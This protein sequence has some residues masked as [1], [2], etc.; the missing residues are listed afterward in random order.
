MFGAES[1]VARAAKSART[2]QRMFLRLRVDGDGA[3]RSEET[4]GGC[5]S[6]LSRRLERFA[7]RSLELAIYE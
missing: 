4:P 2:A 6:R 5:L 7:Q 3:W 1:A